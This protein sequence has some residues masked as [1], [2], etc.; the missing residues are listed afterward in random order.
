[1][2]LRKVPAWEGAPEERRDSQRL[3]V[4]RLRQ[5]PLKE[6]AT[7]RACRG[8]GI[9][10]CR[11]RGWADLGCGRASGQGVHEGARLKE[12]RIMRGVR[13]IEVEKNFLRQVWI[14]EGPLLMGIEGLAD[15]GQMCLRK[16]C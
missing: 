4:T 10:T 15:L 3:G 6:P 11:V 13:R 9:C 5:K 16:G 14:P 2:C 7:R 1:M 12:G 8:G